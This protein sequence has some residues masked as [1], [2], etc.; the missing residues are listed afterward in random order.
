[1]HRRTLLISAACGA[2]GCFTPG[3]SLLAGLPVGA[4]RVSVRFESGGAHHLLPGG[5]EVV[6]ADLGRKAVLQESSRTMTAMLRPP[7]PDPR[8]LL[9]LRYVDV[10]WAGDRILLL[11]AGHGRID[12][13]DRTGQ[14]QGSLG[15]ED[16]CSAPRALVWDRGTC[17]LTDMARH[18]V[19]Q[20]DERGGIVKCI[21]GLGEGT[22]RLNGPTAMALDREGLLHVL[23]CGGGRIDVWER[24][25]RHVGR[26]GE[27]VLSPGCRGLALL[28]GRQAVVIDTW[29]NAVVFPGGH[30]VISSSERV[31][32]GGR[33]FRA[34]QVSCRDRELLL[35]A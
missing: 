5:L 10:A 1:M 8:S 2:L 33:V 17:W 7:G 9:R 27:P 14:F 28:D 20:L 34:T 29:R 19:L 31:L 6:L 30:G 32:D 23:S 25:G 13:Y 11:D 16:V 12:R 4:P 26:Y 22:G 21:G 18:E 24:G 35:S 3:M 15:L